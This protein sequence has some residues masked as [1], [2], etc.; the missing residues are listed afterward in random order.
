[1]TSKFV[2]TCTCYSGFGAADCS[3]RLGDPPNV[4]GV[5]IDNGGICEKSDCSNAIISGD[6]FLDISSLTCK[7]THFGVYINLLLLFI[8]Y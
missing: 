5:N 1:M 2:G 4:I 8:N 6:M 3:R 7:M